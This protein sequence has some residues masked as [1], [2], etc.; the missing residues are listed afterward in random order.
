M[1]DGS[2]Q[3]MHKLKDGNWATTDERIRQQEF[4]DRF[5]DT[6]FAPADI[7]PSYTGTLTPKTG[8]TTH[9]TRNHLDA[10]LGEILGSPEDILAGKVTPL[11]IKE[12]GIRRHVLGMMRVLNMPIWNSVRD[13]LTKE[14]YF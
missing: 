8:G 14:G 2:E 10:Y 3:L 12:A 4:E 13:K 7:R 5:K 9:S 11:P 1:P 6:A